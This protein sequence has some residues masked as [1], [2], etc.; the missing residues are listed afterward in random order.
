MLHIGFLMV[1]EAYRSFGEDPGMEEH[2]ISEGDGSSSAEKVVSPAALCDTCGG[3]LVK[4]RVWMSMGFPYYLKPWGK[5]L[6]MSE[7]TVPWLCPKCGR[8]YYRLER[9]ERVHREW[10]RL[11]DELKAE[12]ILRPDILDDEFVSYDMIKKIKDSFDD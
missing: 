4:S 10:S 1:M 2:G 11:P 12:K 9:T 3:Y 6:K 8:V 5:I 7:V